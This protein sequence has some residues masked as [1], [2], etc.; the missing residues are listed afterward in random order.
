MSPKN[1]K[2]FDKNVL[3]SE[4]EIMEQE[5]YSSST[6]I[7]P[8]NQ[9][10]SKSKKTTRPKSRVEVVQQKPI[11][12]PRSFNEPVEKIAVELPKRLVKKMRSLAVE[13]E[14]RF[15]LEAAAAFEAYLKRYKNI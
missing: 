8:E 4:D 1:D 6:K 5:Y 2:P 7:K 10:T 9:K 14:T 15:N 13:K 12:K 3:L 11:T